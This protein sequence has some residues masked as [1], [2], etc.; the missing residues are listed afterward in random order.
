M[1]GTKKVTLLTA[2]LLA[3]SLL[4]GCSIYKTSGESLK[5]KKVIKIGISQIIEHPALDSAR[6]GFIDALKSKGFE[7]GKNLKIDF[8]NAQ[9]DIPTAQSIAS[10]FVS[11]KEDMILAISTQCAQSAYNATKTTPILITAVTDPVKAGIAKSLDKPGTNVT[12]T[13]DNVPIDKQFE[14]LKKLVPNAKN[15]GILYNTSESNSEIQVEEAKKASGK[16]G[17][18][19]ITSG[20]TN[21]NDVPQSLNSLISKIDVLFVPTDNAVVS[22]MPIISS[23]CFKK[24]IPIIGAESGSVKSGAVAC[25]GIDYYKLGYQTG[26]CAVD[27]I[28]GKKPQDT[29]ITLLNEMQLTINTDAVKKLNITIPQDLEAAAE[30]VKGG[31]N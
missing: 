25:M 13:S 4:G 21:V 18:N 20:I 24:N 15:V 27:I 5:S 2:A 3:A 17:L 12:G 9:G 1:V 14:L 29:P 19:I 8:Q 28:N 7:D 16:F 11:K 10:N 22:S 31:V 26:L 6:K 30:K 23:A